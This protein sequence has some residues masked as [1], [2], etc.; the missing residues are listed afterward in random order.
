MTIEVNCG[1]VAHSK[2]LKAEAGFRETQQNFDI[3]RRPWQTVV[4]GW[5]VPWRWKTTSHKW[6]GAIR[7]RKWQTYSLFPDLNQNKTNRNNAH[8]AI[9]ATW[10]S[11]AHIQ[12][13]MHFAF[14]TG[15]PSIRNPGKWK[16]WWQTSQLQYILYL[17]CLFIRSQAHPSP[18][19]E[20][21]HETMYL[22]NLWTANNRQEHRFEDWFF[23]FFF[24]YHIMGGKGT[25]SVLSSVS[26]GVWNRAPAGSSL[27]TSKSAC[28]P[29]GRS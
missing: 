14:E 20:G 24:F 23:F 9:R 1:P 5:N 18:F 29:D 11:P 16:T 19:M 7:F 3:S 15:F 4:V 12:C 17:K 13:R 22:Q 10:H 28:N 27:Y 6:F 26:F 8:A 21:L 25:G 2:L